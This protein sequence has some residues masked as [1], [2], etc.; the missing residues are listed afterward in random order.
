VALSSGIARP[1]PSRGALELLG[2]GAIAIAIGA[3]SGAVPLAGV[4]VLLV[5][6]GLIG[7]AALGLSLPGGA[8][9]LLVL[10]HLVSGQLYIIGLLPERFSAV[11]DVIVVA[12]FAVAT[13]V[14]RGTPA[15]TW[16]LLAY[17][18]LVAL[19]L[20]NPLTPGLGYGVLG[21]RQL[22]MAVLV[23]VA[24]R[25][26]PVSPRDV[27]CVLAAL[28]FGW[29]VNVALA[30][31]QWLGAFTGAE[32]RWIEDLGSTYL[33]GD[34]IRLIGAT[35]SNQ[36][37]AFLAAIAMP[38]VV[39]LAFRAPA[40]WKRTAALALAVASA[41]VLFGSLVRSGLVG[42]IAGAGVALAVTARS[43]VDRR[44]LLQATVLTAVVLWAAAGLAPSAILPANK[45]DV[46]QQRV[47]SILRPGQDFAFQ[48]RQ[49]QTWPFAL[50][51]I[52][53]HPFGAGPGSAGPLSQAR[54]EQAPLGRVVPDNGY[55]LVAVQ[56]GVLGA[57]L[58]VWMLGALLVAL[59]RRA[60]AGS[61]VAAA[62]AGALAAAL[63][64]MLAG[65]Y[66]S[67]VAPATLLGVLIGLGL[68]PGPEPETAPA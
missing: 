14:R 51:Q 26:A 15:L 18:G 27:R 68:R 43:A 28:A 7:I 59:A 5:V 36:D 13:L 1:A 40:G 31:R 6:A 11:L 21:A 37:F 42:G 8:L 3:A 65:N 63:V 10:G 24:V 32:L 39:V 47:L 12:L 52:R 53:D 16:L 17:L 50:E 4:V 56:L 22:A 19:E 34:Q 46:L 33:V 30:L 49:E 2:G 23:I 62:A 44:R 61:P 64:A 54:P 9:V 58:F 60:R 41:T 25:D 38:A 48:A 45:A 57:A 20:F 29:V 35:Q 66:W 55:L 67:L